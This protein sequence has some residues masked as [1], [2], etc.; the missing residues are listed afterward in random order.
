[1]IKNSEE[2]NLTV[3]FPEFELNFCTRHDLDSFRHS[4]IRDLSVLLKMNLEVIMKRTPHK[5]VAG[6]SS[7]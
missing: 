7:N 4:K 3:F 1:M 2:V 5:L 6:T